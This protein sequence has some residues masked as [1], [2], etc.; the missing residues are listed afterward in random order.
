MRIVITPFILAT[1]LLLGGCDKPEPVAS[2]Q[3][4]S[5]ETAAPASSY[6]AH[7]TV[8]GSFEF[9]RDDVRNAIIER[10]IKINNVSHIGNMLAR[11]ADDVGA[12]KQVFAEAEAIEFCSSTISRAMMEADPHNIVFCPYIITVYTLPEQPDTVHI[13]YRHPELVGDEASRQSLQAVE[14]LLAAIVK[15]VVG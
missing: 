9:I 3:P 5:N 12:S 11:T 2:S 10:G 4:A 15:Q 6:M 13:A 7:Y 8:E 14:D 1:A